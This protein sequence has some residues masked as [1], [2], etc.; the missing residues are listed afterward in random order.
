MRELALHITDL[1]ENSIA[2]QSKTIHIEISEDT[3]ANRLKLAVIDDG[4]GMSEEMVKKITDPFFTSRTTRKVGLGIPLLKASAESCNG[5]LE[6][7][8]KPGEGTQVLVEFQLDHIDRMP[9][10]DLATTIRNLIICS[11]DV[12]FII[13]YSR[14]GRQFDLD[15]QPIIEELDGLSLTEPAVLGFLRE[16]ISEGITSVRNG[17]SQESSI[18]EEAWTKSSH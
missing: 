14:D 3:T 15:T 2:A 4:V 10:G 8:S 13:N 6:I 17:K 11:P 16:L 12:R 9:L 1:V 5:F 7:K 18:L